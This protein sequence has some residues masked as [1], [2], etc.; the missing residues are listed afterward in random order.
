PLEAGV[1]VEV[2]LL[3]RAA[4]GDPAVAARL[5]AG[6]PGA[7]GESGEE[8]H[9]QRLA[10]VGAG[11]D[12]IPEE[13]D[14]RIA[15]DVRAGDLQPGGGPVHGDIDVERRLA[16]GADRDGGPAERGAEP[17]RAEGPGDVPAQR[18]GVDEAQTI[19]A[20]GPG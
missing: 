4:P 1:E 20:G 13:L 16:V 18:P 3:A 2:G 10:A 11:G 14:G 17:R 7:L 15:V 19:G 5:A 12:H 9:A 8:W 6:R